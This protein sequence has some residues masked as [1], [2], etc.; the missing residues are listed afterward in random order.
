[1]EKKRI[2]LLLPASLMKNYAK[3][4]IDFGITQTHGFTQ[5]LNCVK[6]KNEERKENAPYVDLHFKLGK[7]K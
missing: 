7:Q 4:C 1:M 3:T 5:F 6:E 2:N